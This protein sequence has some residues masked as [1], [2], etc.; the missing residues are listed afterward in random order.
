MKK[1][2]LN[3]ESEAQLVDTFVVTS[4]LSTY[5][6]YSLLKELVEEDDVDASMLPLEG[7]KFKCLWNGRGVE[8][9]HQE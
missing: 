2:S 7:K 5:F 4:L 1:L 3:L 9:N 6:C 8:H